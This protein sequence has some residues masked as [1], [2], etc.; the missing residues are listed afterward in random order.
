VQFE[1]R[2]GR[3]SREFAPASPA[4]GG[5]QDLVVDFPFDRPRFEVRQ[6]R[7]RYRHIDIPDAEIS[8]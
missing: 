8:L 5:A 2:R 1:C 7:E 3:A 6:A 4:K